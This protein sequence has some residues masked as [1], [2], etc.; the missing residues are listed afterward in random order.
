[1]PYWW[2]SYSKP[3]LH[4]LLAFHWPS[5]VSP[6]ERSLGHLFNTTI[7]QY[8]NLLFNEMKHMKNTLDLI[9]TQFWFEDQFTFLSVVCAPQVTAIVSNKSLIPSTIDIIPQVWLPLS[10]PVRNIQ[11]VRFPVFV[12]SRCCSYNAEYGKSF[13]PSGE[14]DM[15]LGSNA[16]IKYC[17][18]SEELWWQLLFWAQ[19]LAS[20]EV[21]HLQVGWSCCIMMMYPISHLSLDTYKVN[22]SYSDT[23]W[24][25]HD[26]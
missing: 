17:V 6:I 3:P 21:L 10:L 15:P 19:V 11:S 5:A 23:P 16:Y 26:V 9:S 24:P 4:L 20:Y 1:M 2:A 22:S 13:L 12:T 25:F 18:L 8:F 14:I 7:I